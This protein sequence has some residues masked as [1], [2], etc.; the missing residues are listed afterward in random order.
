MILN[1]CHVILAINKLFCGPLFSAKMT[2]YQ[3][4]HIKQQNVL[5]L[6][7]MTHHQINNQFLIIIIIDAWKTCVNSHFFE[8]KKNKK[9]QFVI[10]FLLEK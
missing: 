10:A 5:Y 2:I 9:I 4:Y 8:T 6:C 7:F 1:L 3:Y